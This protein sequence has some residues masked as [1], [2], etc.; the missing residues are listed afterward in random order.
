MIRFEYTDCYKYTCR[1]CKD[2]DQCKFTKFGKISN[3]S[4]CLESK[5]VPKPPKITKASWDYIQLGRQLSMMRN[6]IQSKKNEIMY[7]DILSES[8]RSNMK[9][10][11]YSFTDYCA[12]KF[13]L[14]SYSRFLKDREEYRDNDRFVSDMINTVVILENERYITVVSSD[15]KVRDW[16][17]KDLNVN[18]YGQY[19]GN[20]GMK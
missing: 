6:I 18:G 14:D 12:Y 15:K 13:A 7:N 19:V 9:T 1:D 2:C 10:K 16:I 5:L 8:L 20:G 11:G 17:N 3:R 4:I